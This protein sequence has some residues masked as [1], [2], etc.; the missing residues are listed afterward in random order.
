MVGDL[1]DHMPTLAAVE[2]TRSFEDGAWMTSRDTATR[3]GVSRRT[4]QRWLLG[5]ELI[6]PLERSWIDGGE[7]VW[8]RYRP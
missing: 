1:K 4:A 5:L 2:L 8:R 6:I 7:L 3:F